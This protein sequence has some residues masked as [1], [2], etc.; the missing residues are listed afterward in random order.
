MKKDSSG[1]NL[2]SFLLESDNCFKDNGQDFRSILI[3]AIPV[4]T[5]LFETRGFCII[6]VCGERGTASLG[7]VQS[8][9]FTVLSLGD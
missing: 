6:F 7:E 9:L 5:S 2:L 4:S 1:I 3:L 8:M